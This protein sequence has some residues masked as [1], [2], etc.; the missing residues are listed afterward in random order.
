[1]SNKVDEPSTE[2]V[3]QLNNGGR[4][5][6]INAL[7]FGFTL[8]LLVSLFVAENPTSGGPR[9]VIAALVLI[10][11]LL[12]QL[13]WWVI[14]LL[15]GLRGSNSAIRHPLLLSQLIS[16]SGIFLIGLLS[17]NQ[18]SITDVLLTVI[19]VTIIY[20]YIIRRF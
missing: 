8:V 11:A 14:K 15:N 18:L 16:L 12:F 9:I 20:L 4:P 19:M 10:F 7:F 3:V 5:H 2:E 1:M 17:L 13:V 6:L